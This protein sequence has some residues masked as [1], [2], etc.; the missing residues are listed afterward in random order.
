M[1]LGRMQLTYGVVGK[2]VQIYL[3]EAE[4]RRYLTECAQGV[5]G[6][7]FLNAPCLACLQH[8][9]L[10]QNSQQIKINKNTHEQVHVQFLR[11]ILC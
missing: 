9:C 3:H 7:V 2:R 10:I 8:F 4:L 1:Q 6:W 5:G 11:L